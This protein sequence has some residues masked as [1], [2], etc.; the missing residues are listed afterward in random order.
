[1]VVPVE[2]VVAG[3]IVETLVVVMRHSTSLAVLIMMKTT[4]CLSTRHNGEERLD[5]AAP[6]CHTLLEKYSKL[7]TC[8]TRD[9]C[10]ATESRTLWPACFWLRDPQLT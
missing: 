7:H 2:G 1:M 9:T 6:C 3:R 10:V 5:L 4:G 8:S